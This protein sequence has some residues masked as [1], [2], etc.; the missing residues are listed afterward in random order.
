M[1]A[2]GL[3]TDMGKCTA[4]VRFRG[5]SGYLVLAITN[6]LTHAYIEARI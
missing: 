4:R 1:G 5:S 2:I 6:D 3:I